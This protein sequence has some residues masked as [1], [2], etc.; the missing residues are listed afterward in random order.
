MNPEQAHESN[1]NQQINLLSAQLLELREQLNHIT[2]MSQSGNQPAPP[3]IN[4]NH[5]E[6]EPKLALPERY[7]GNHKDARE[8]I[9]SIENYFRIK[10]RSYQT[11]EAKTGLVGS[12]LT[13]SAR[14][15]FRIISETNL[16]LLGD[17]NKFMENLKSVFLDPNQRQNAQR[18]LRNFNQGKMSALNYTT[19]FMEYAIDAGYDDNAK[20]SMFYAGLNDDIKD[21]LSLNPNLPTT[22]DQF[23]NLAIQVDNRIFERRQERKNRGN[24]GT[25]TPRNQSQ[26]THT[27]TSHQPMDIDTTKKFQPLTAEEKKRRRDNNLCLYCGGTG[28]V[29]LNCTAKTKQSRSVTLAKPKNSKE[30]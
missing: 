18:I 30:L 27:T 24:P 9:A 3:T 11:N 12:L 8:F 14:S 19:K 28:H 23:A 6:P 29:A 10:P 5:I 15:W 7:N 17:Y 21:A 20:I 22:F 16:G 26:W 13:G 4:T 25:Y 2:A 1:P